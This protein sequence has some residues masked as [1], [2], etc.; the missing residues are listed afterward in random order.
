MADVRLMDACIGDAVVR[1]VGAMILQ[2]RTRMGIA[3]VVTQ[4]TGG[5][6]TV[7]MKDTTR[8]FQARVCSTT[9]AAPTHCS[10]VLHL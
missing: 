4:C 9:V 1:A 5:Y 3:G 10:V 8:Y 2:M 6:Q 7:L